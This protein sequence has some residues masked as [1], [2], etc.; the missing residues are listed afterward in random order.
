MVELYIYCVGFSRICILSY[1]KKIKEKKIHEQIDFKHNRIQTYH[2]Q[3]TNFGSVEYKILYLSSRN[4]S[5]S[6][7]YL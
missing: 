3:G 6:K 7:K 5:F 4:L 2:V 1:N